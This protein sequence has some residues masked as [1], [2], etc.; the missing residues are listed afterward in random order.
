MWE[1]SQVAFSTGA[2]GRTIAR[3]DAWAVRCSRTSRGFLLVD[4]VESTTW[5]WSKS[6]HLKET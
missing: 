5:K 1:G 2:F 3:S 6:F 4:V